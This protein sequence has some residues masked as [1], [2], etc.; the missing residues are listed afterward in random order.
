MKEVKRVRIISLVPSW[1]ETLIESGIYPVGRTRF[2]IHPKGQVEKIPVVGG[3]K[4]VN[5]EL[6]TELKPN[7][8]ILDQEENP[9]EMSEQGFPFWS[10]H[11]KDGTSLTTALEELSILLK[12]EKLKKLAQLS[13]Q[14]NHAAPSLIDF[15][16]N[17]AC[18]EIL[19]PW[20]KNDSKNV[21]YM[22]WKKPWMTVTKQTYIAYVLQKIGFE[23][24]DWPNVQTKYPEVEIDLKSDLIYLFSSEPFP[25]L[26]I[27]S[28]LLQLDLKSAIVD[29][30]KLSWFGIRSLR[31]LQKAL[32][33]SD[34]K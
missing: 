13:D 28:E 19:K 7:I 15:K 24:Y 31:F 21:A 8:L 4:T 29:G 34:P 20:H 14:I 2:C 27:K 26:K 12:N 16:N 22:I 11:V 25:F 9:K 3:T 18:I 33:L 10:S 23:I 1:T 32:Q 17:E 5:W 6:I 30:E